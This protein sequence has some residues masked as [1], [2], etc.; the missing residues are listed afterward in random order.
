VPTINGISVFYPEKVLVNKV[1]P[2]VYIA[3]L[4]AD[5]LEM[6]GENG[7]LIIGPGKLRY[8]FSYTAPS[9][10]SPRKI[11]FKY[12]LENVDAA[13][14]NAGT[15]RQAEYTNL[16]PG[17]YT[18]KVLACNSDGIWN[19]KGATLTFTVR[20]FFY[21]TAYFYL[22]VIVAA[23]LMLY[24]IYKWRVNAVEKRN[25]ELRKVNGELDRFVYSASHDLR[26]PLASVL[27][28]VN[29][30]RLE[31]GANFEGYLDKI[32]SSVL[33]LDGFIRDII[34]FSRN[35]RVEIEAEAIDFRSLITEI[36]DNLK[37][38]DEKDKIKRLVKVEGDRIFYSDKKRLAVILN[39]LI[40][41][42]IKYSNP[43]EENSFIE[44]Y[45]KQNGRQ[46][47]LQVKDNG[48]G[49]GNEHISSI[50]KMFYRADAKSRGSG[51]GLYIVKETLDKIQGTISVQSEYGKGSMFTVRLKALKTSF[52]ERKEN[53]EVKSSGENF[54]LA[55]QPKSNKI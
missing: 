23:S 45:V 10:V 21:Q 54:K 31:K 35:A 5:D 52:A 7:P 53:V 26:A 15:E 41:N 43:H 49:I 17:D 29:I 34:D 37:Y 28:L 46:V 47:L 25:V 36:F 14:I 38:L 13:W 30:A 39:N 2:P 22:L 3:T 12:K 1:L 8:T 4:R 24:G 48:I 19:E 33:K 32:E 20:P 27:G 44:V 11:Q 40:A 55:S 16:S 18:F 42:A 51:I 9:F 6:E 50:F